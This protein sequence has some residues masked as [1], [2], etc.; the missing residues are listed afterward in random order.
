MQVAKA[1]RPQ[2]RLRLLYPAAHVAVHEHDPP[3]FHG[4]LSA[5]GQRCQP[6]IVVAAD[7]IDGGDAF[8]L[9]DGLRCDDVAGVQDEVDSAQDLEETIRQAVEKLRTVGVSDHPDARR[10]EALGAG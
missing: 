5:L 10:Q 4:D 8:E 2:Q 6:S 3:A 9:G 1:E 7:G